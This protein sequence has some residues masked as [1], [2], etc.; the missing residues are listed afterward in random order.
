MS[1]ILIAYA[2]EVQH[3]PIPANIDWARRAILL[4][5]GL[6]EADDI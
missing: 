2:C 4:V 3:L 1:Q 6:I 5:I